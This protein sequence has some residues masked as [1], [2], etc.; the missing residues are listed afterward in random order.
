M[1]ERA[2][3]YSAIRDYFAESGALEVDL[4]LIGASSVTD[5]NI[6]AIDVELDNQSHYLQSSPEYFMKRLLAD[7]PVAIY[8]LGKAFRAD[9]VGS[10]HN[11]EFTM[12]EWYRPGFS[13]NA[14]I[15][16]IIALLTKLKPDLSINRQS[17]GEIFND[18]FDAD[19][20][21]LNAE[22]LE[23]LAKRFLEFEFTCSEKNTWLDLLFSHCIEPKMPPGLTVIYDYPSSQCALAKTEELPSGIEVAKRFEVFWNGLEIANGYWELTDPSIQEA[24]FHAD[25][26]VRAKQGLPQPL[27]DQ[28]FLRAL[29]KG[30]PECA[31]VAL[32]VDRLLMCLYNENDIR[33]VIPFG[34]AEL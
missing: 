27:L 9:E 31:G 6:H 16:D 30:I 1:V 3:V 17:Y 33:N 18:I 11:P 19:P 2:Q 24:R 20:H 10:K 21:T 5:P 22:Q 26:R 7:Y 34:F 8:Y 13:D 25:N 29:K 14:L 15:D 32:G 28:A 12:L 23:S 4:P